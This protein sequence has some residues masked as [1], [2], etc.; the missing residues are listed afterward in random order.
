MN[1]LLEYNNYKIRLNPTIYTHKKIMKVVISL[2]N[3]HQKQYYLRRK[4]QEHPELNK[5]ILLKTQIKIKL[6]VK[7]D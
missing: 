5:I 4:V 7:V 1:F 3:Y 6:L 2:K